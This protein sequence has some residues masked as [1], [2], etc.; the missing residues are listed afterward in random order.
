MSVFIS[1]LMPEV[2]LNSS[3]T[4]AMGHRHPRDESS[5]REGE[6]G[7]VFL[8]QEERL[9]SAGL[10]VDVD[11]THLLHLQKVQPEGSYQTHPE[12]PLPPSWGT[13]YCFSDRSRW[14]L[15]GVSLATGLWTW[16]E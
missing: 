8:L 15:P 3:S 13:P 4:S 1:V 2:T 16:L 9:A 12:A 10:S 14:A 5:R 11:V 7:Q 6:R